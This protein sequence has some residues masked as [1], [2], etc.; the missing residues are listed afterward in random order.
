VRDG[1]P[2]QVADACRVTDDP[3][4]FRNDVLSLLAMTPA[5]RREVSQTAYVE[6]LG[7]EVRLA[8]IPALLEEAARGLR[9]TEPERGQ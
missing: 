9:Q 8:R 1:L 4:Q 2:T 6:R 3:R 7:W 5:K